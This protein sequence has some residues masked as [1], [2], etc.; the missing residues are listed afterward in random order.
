M[1]PNDKPFAA[2]HNRNV[3]NQLQIVDL[4][5]KKVVRM[6]KKK[7]TR[8]SK[9]KRITLNIRGITYE[10]FLDQFE[11]LPNSR[12][13]QLK[14]FIDENKQ[15]TELHTLN[16]IC[17]DY[18]LVANEFFFDKD[19]YVFNM[20]LNY[21]SNGKINIDRSLCPYFMRE[22]L[23]YWGVSEVY[24]SDCC[25]EKHFTR[26]KGIDERL[27][28]ENEIVKKYN[29]KEDF[30]KIL[31]KLREKAWNIL[32]QLEEESWASIVSLK[33]IYICLN[34]CHL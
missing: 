26:L 25:T 28:M 24:M 22:Q 34:T 16:N 27:D 8:K 1:K 19:P 5:Q 3:D 15:E 2:A 29:T 18:D 30:G 4:D 32:E 23:K 6:A 9:S 11:K 12:L 31:P 21:F 20:I 17:D 7:Q 14:A 10:L 13:G 33:I